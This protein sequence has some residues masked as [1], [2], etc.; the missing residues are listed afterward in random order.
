MKSAWRLLAVGGAIPL[1]VLV[2]PL[3]EWWARAYAGDWNDPSGETMIVLAAG[4]EYDPRLLS[5]SS[6]L[7]TQYAWLAW[8]AGGFAKIVVSGRAAPNMADN[9]IARG[10]PAA[11][12]LVESQSVSTRDS[13]EALAA[14]AGKWPPEPV[15][16]TS[17]YHMY[18]ARRAFEKAGLRVRPRPFPDAIK[19]AQRVNGRWTAFCLLVEETAKI[20]AYRW[21]GWT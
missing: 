18:R 10:V 12:V 1:L 13:A 6:Y 2:T 15:L 14:M 5:Y 11:A 16:L 7:R 20:A 17:D 21:R 19:A 3:T 4:D 9:L 8:K